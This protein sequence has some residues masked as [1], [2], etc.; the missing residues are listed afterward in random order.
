MNNIKK[1]YCGGKFTFDFQKKRYE[2]DVLND[3][4]CYLLGNPHLLLESNKPIKLK[5]NLEYIG[6]FYF[7]TENMQD[8]YIVKK[9][10]QM[11]DESTDCI[12]L[13]N[14][15]LCPGTISELIYAS[16]LAK[17]I[18]IF[19]IKQ[20]DN[21]ETESSL[22][23]ACWYPIILSQ[24]LNN[25]KTKIFSAKSLIEAQEQIDKLIKNL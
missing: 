16:M 3:Y 13:L 17:N 6:P 11:I 21:E 25:N 14:D 4:R 10:K 18:Y 2:T 12:F 23:T 9:E 22:H 24:Q 15:G 5:E 19:F 20:N 1:L 8:I 7:E